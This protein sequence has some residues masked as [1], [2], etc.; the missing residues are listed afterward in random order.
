MEERNLENVLDELNDEPRPAA[1]RDSRV[2][3]CA[4]IPPETALK[5]FRKITDAVKRD[6]REYQHHRSP[7]QKRA[8][9][10]AREKRRRSKRREPIDPL[11]YW[12]SAALRRGEV[13]RSETAESDRGKSGR[14]PNRFSLNRTAD[15]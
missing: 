3:R 1:A 11:T 12:A 5:R 10:A 7:R 8:E 14:G 9:S 4:G 2:I 15:P 13:S 6:E